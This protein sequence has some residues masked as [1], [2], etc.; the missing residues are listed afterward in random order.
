[1]DAPQGHWKT[2]IFVAGLRREPLTA[3]FVRDG[4]ITRAWFRASA[5]QVLAPTPSP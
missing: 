2:T 3:H 4:P 5:E 1:M